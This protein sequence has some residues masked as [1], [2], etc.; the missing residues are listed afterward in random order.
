MTWAPLQLN[1][2]RSTKHFLD[3]VNVIGDVAKNTLAALLPGS[4]RA[5]SYWSGQGL[6]M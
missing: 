4:R 2:V 1:L 6:R 5:R 3:L